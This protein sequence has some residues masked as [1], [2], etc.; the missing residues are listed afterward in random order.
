M[1]NE[2]AVR[3]LC[4]KQEITEILYRYARALDR[5]DIELLRSCFHPDSTHDHGPFE[6][7]SSDFCV[8][9]IELLESLTATQ[10]HIGNVL[11]DLEGDV[12]WSEAYWVAYHRIPTVTAGDGVMASRGAETDLFIGGRYIDRFE[13]RDGAWRIARRVGIH[14]W[15]RYEPAN[16]DGFFATDP[17]KRGLRSRADPA[18]KRQ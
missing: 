2:A 5:V 8:W 15:Q 3:A 9:A 1:G 18:Y 16:D 6:G 12:A 4:D 11:I 17:R 13:R 7:T 14:D 10:H